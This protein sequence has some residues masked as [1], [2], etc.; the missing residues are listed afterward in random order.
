M[1]AVETGPKAA[2]TKEQQPVVATTTWRDKISTWWLLGGIIVV[3]VVIYSFA[4]GKDTLFIGEQET[5]STQNWLIARF[6]E[7]V[8]ANNFVVTA[9]HKFGD[10]V[11]W[12]V[13]QL[14]PLLSQPDFPWPYP[15]IGWLGVFAIAVWIGLAIAGWRI[16]LLVAGSFLAFGYLG[17]WADS[18]DTLII[19]FISVVIAVIVGIP[20][21]VWSG[22]SKAAAAVITPILDIFQTFPS[23]TY[24]LPL[25]IFFG[26][27]PSASVV[28]TLLFAFPAVVRIAAYGIRTV[29]ETSLEATRS[30][31][32]TKMQEIRKVQL[33]MAKRT[34]IV[35][36]NQTTMA[37][38]S[39]VIIAAYVA[40]PGLG[41]P[42][43][44][45]LQAIRVGDAFVPGLAIVI[46]AIM[47]DRTTTAA[48]E[49]AERLQ[50]AGGGNRRLRLIMLGVTGV[51]TL[52]CVWLSHTYAWAAGFPESSIGTHIADRVQSISDWI[53]TNLDTQTTWIK[54]KFTYW[55]LNPMQDL[56]AN[57]PWFVTGLAI[58]AIA[59]VLGGRWAAA[60]TAICLAG[61]YWLD[62]WYNS[63]VT[64]NMTIVATAVVMVLALIFGVWMGRSTTA[65]NLIRP[66][67]DAGQTLPPFVYLIPV[68]ALFGATRFT[69]IVAAVAFAAP[70]SIKI[71]ADGIRGVSPTTV[72]AATASGSNRWQIITKVQVPM[73]RGSVVLA[74]NQGLLYVLSMSV[75]GALVGAG[76]L[77]YDVVQGF[78]QENFQ[79]KGLA[80][81][82]SIVLIGI[83]LDRITRRAAMRT[84]R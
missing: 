40:A 24:L 68:L 71:V 16:A 56:L 26:I 59:A 66:W 42:V 3:W 57:S 17:F 83:M 44:A 58:I 48:S 25:A 70:A 80:A 34:I 64:L 81:S 46:M 47:L 60:T 45:G 1:T 2:V 63:M 74:A 77:G 54:D 51:A 72:E 53:S 14:Q 29:S 21:A 6:D 30:L 78:S 19:T 7:F 39:M 23:F 52:V 18:I 4:Q 43:L 84:T 41:G 69:A 82:I 61:I 13:E 35:G 67:L 12:L 32:Q 50:R 33:P 37:A 10:F 65:D 38:L 73:A 49:R 15:K 75:I 8:N 55:I 27:G 76:A 9:L 28:A 79:G 36:I 31:G 11:G 5:T 20:L 62:L 22:R